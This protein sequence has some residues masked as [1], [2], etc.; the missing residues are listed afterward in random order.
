MKAVFIAEDGRSFNSELECKNYE[1]TLAFQSTIQTWAD[2][3]YSDKR[4]Q[5]KQALRHVL[6]FISDNP[7]LINKEQLRIAA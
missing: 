3:K 1:S 2:G 5:P 7:H 4:G 6:D